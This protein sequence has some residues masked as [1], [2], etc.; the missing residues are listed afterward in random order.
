MPCIYLISKVLNAEILASNLNFV[1]GNTFSCGLDSTELVT[2]QPLY[3][4][5]LHPGVCSWQGLPEGLCSPHPSDPMV[6]DS[7]VH[8]YP[9]EIRR[10]PALWAQKA[11]EPHWA[12]L[13]LSMDD[14][15]SLQDWCGPEETVA[16]MDRAGVDR[17]L[18]VGWYWEQA[19]STDLQNQCLIEWCQKYHGRFHAFASIHSGLFGT[20]PVE[21]TLARLRDRG[22]SGIGEIHPAIQGFDP[23]RSPWRE[24]MAWA[25]SHQWPVLFHVTEPLGRPH[26]GTIETPLRC[27]LDLAL[28]HPDLPIILAHYGGLSFFQELN[29]FVRKRFKRVYYDTAAS[30]LLYDD[31]V[32]RLACEVVGAEKVL[33]GTD[34]PLRIR[35]SQEAAGFDEWLERAR[36][37]IGDPEWEKA[38]LGENLQRL[39]F[40]SG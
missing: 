28:R 4:K 18:L 40:K 26:P 16:R 38:V 35:R 34:F 1:T 19:A 32:L 8:A 21:D 27:F 20:E 24:I 11:N 5:A 9:A 29:P 7:H 6:I 30:P 37:V 10:N 17:A 36:A 22:F 39:L 12:S 2:G 15:V 23:L 13:H 31:R 25:E 14:R 33:W 3:D